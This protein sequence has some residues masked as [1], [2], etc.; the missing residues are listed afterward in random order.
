MNLPPTDLD[1][2][3]YDKDSVEQFPPIFEEVPP[4]RIPGNPTPEIVDFPSPEEMALYGY[5]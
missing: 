4:V 5:N 1:D 3:S 2:G